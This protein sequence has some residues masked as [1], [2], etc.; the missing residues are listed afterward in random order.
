MALAPT[1]TIAGSPIAADDDPNTTEPAGARKFSPPT[2]A[3][4][5]QQ[6]WIY[7]EDGTGTFIV[8]LW[9][10]DPTNTNWVKL[11]SINLASAGELAQFP[12]ELGATASLTV[13]VGSA[14]GNDTTKCPYGFGIGGVAV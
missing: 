8:T 4:G 9:F 3:V 13:Q 6:L 7:R 5:P 10:K 12:Y 14:G 1:Y 2:L 11:G